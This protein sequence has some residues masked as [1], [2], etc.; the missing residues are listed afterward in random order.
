MDNLSRHTIAPLLHG[1]WAGWP[2]FRR[3]LGTRL[4]YLGTDAKTVRT[5]L[6][7]AKV[8]TTIAHDVIPDPAEAAAA[9]EKLS[10]VLNVLQN[11]EQAG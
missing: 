7:H 3:G 6:R 11:R 8:S 5:I 10:K 9:M 1:K 2:S 4:S